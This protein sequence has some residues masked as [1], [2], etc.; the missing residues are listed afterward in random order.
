MT[1]MDE[2]FAAYVRSRQHRLLR[3]AYLV[4]GDRQTAEDLLQQAFVKLALRWE[5]IR[6][7]HPDAFVR[8]VLYRDAIS[9]W[10][11]TRR[12]T[13]VRI[14][15]HPRPGEE[16]RVETRVDLERALRRLAPRQRA[17][18]VLRYYED[19]SEIETAEILGIAVGTVKS[20]A[21]DGLARIRAL[22]PELAPT[23]T[24]GEP[25]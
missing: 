19:R 5:R 14:P 11:S 1:P 8:R 7:E 20:Q 23:M 3:A 13:L 2:D 22:V 9:N 6:D 25:S 12:E 4:C 15:E 24:G 18:L 10:R 16:T 17:V 21:H